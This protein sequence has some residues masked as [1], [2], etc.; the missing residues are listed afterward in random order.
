M[1]AD[2]W[3][4]HV[5]PHGPL[6]PVAREVARSLWAPLDVIVVRKLGVPWQPELAM[7]AVGEDGVEVKNAD[8]VAG[9]NVGEADFARVRALEDIY[10]LVR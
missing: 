8:I 1:A 3:E 4:D 6:V 9:A 5:R 10:E 2:R 7:G